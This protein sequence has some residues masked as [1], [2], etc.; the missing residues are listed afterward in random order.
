M[1]DNHPAAYDKGPDLSR[2]IGLSDGVFAFSITFLAVSISLPNIQSGAQL[3]E[4]LLSMGPR[5]L[6]Y[7]ISF[8]VIALLWTA[9]H[10]HF[11]FITRYDGTLIRLNLLFLMT[12]TFI[13]F[14][15]TIISSYGDFQLA[16]V[17][18][19]S[20]L[21]V[22]T[23]LFFA[24]WQYATVDRRLVDPDLDPRIVSYLSLRAVLPAFVFVVSIGISFLNP[25]LA[26]YSWALIALLRL[27]LVRFYAP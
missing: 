10:R 18:Y 3:L 27:L 2:I 12:V 26:E 19:A 9:H 11:R 5:I 4:A 23:L 17:V 8:L 13:P 15:T 25:R 22:T 1:R 16:I 14:L 21:T 24:M 20:S 7:A 6:S